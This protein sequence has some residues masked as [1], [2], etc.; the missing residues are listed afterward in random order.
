MNEAIKFFSCPVYT[1][2]L[3]GGAK[4]LG[5]RFPSLGINIAA[6]TPAQLSIS[7]LAISIIFKAV[8]NVLDSLINLFPE[9]SILGKRT[10][11]VSFPI[12]WI[13]ATILE[14]QGLLPQQYKIPFL[15]ISTFMGIYE[16]QQDK[17]DRL[18][19]QQREQI[20]R[21]IINRFNKFFEKLNPNHPHNGDNHLSKK[22]LNDD[23]D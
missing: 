13:A 18:K 22:K 12:S 20:T 19:S 6:G 17:I 10:I 11:V 15:A 23:L 21:P 8:N 5:P 2:V 16:L 1:S 9:E 14:N 7:S 4:F 3:I